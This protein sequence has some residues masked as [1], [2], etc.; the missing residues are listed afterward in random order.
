MN[1]DP[2]TTSGSKAML[3]IG[4]VISALIA[5]ALTMSAVF[6]FVQP[7]GLPDEFTRLGWP[8]NLAIALG[9]VELTCAILYAIPQ[10]AVLGAILLTGYLGGAIAT[11]VR[12][13]EQ[14]V[15]PLVMGV[16]AWVGLYLRDARLRPLVP[17]RT[18]TN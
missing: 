4:R 8:V 3:W 7:E 11:H 10:T 6:K 16:L 9:I 12:I 2:H 18:N 5:L 17:W 14:F 1:S 15:P 13:E